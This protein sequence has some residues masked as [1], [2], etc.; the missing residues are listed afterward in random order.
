MISAPVRG[1]PSDISQISPPR[2]HEQQR[3]TRWPMWR[4]AKLAADLVPREDQEADPLDHLFDDALSTGHQGGL[5]N[6]GIAALAWA[7]LPIEPGPVISWAGLGR[8]NSS[9]RGTEPGLIQ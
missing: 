4:S 3:G 9:S 7:V 6:Y 5:T 8:R 1:T 2:P